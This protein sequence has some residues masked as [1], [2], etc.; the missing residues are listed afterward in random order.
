VADDWNN[1]IQVFSTSGAYLTTIGGTFG[2]NTGALRNPGSVALDAAGNVYVSDQTNSRIQVFAPLVA[3]WAQTNINGFGDPSNRWISSLAPFG[4]QLYAGTAGNGSTRAQ[5]WRRG[6]AGTWSST[7][8]GGFNDSA[9]KGIDHLAEFKGN[10]YAGTWTDKGTGGQL[11]R[12]SNGTGWSPVMTGGFGDPTNGE[13]YHLAAFNDTLYATTWSYTTTHGLEVWRSATGNGGEWT[14]VASNGFGDSHNQAATL[15]V[16]N[17][18]LYAGT[19]NGSGANPANGG[20]VWRTSNGTDWEPVNTGGFGQI[21]NWAVSSFAVFENYLYAGVLGWDSV[22]N[23]PGGQQVWRCAQCDGSDWALVADGAFGH[24]NP[25]DV[26][27]LISSDD[28]LYAVTDDYAAGMG[29]WRT[30]N[31]TAWAQINLD[32]FGNS[33]NYGP[34]FD[35]SVTI[36]N[37]ILYVGTTNSAS[38]GEVWEY[39]SKTSYLPLLKR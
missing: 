16:F 1:R 20:Q 29:V 27:A 24:T 25:R 31:G 34:Y 28:A 7:M 11:W 3:T 5:I 38:G 4:G 2:A 15:E 33:N 19:F 17:G 32:G 12:S 13:V 26:G 10:L 39:L 37:D 8:T 35:H 36:F 9:N 22:H 30:T 23:F 14:K 18:R 21:S 6:A